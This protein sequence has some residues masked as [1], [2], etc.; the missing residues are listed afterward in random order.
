MAVACSPRAVA[1]TSSTRASRLAS[2]ARSAEMII[3]SSFAVAAPPDDVY[4]LMLDVE[5]VAPC[6]PGAHVTGLRDDGAY[7][8]DVKVKLGPVSMTY[9]GTV[10]VEEHDDAERTARL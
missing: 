6:I 1:S 2:L 3:Q 4:R 7:D 8:A 5:K 10:A 9:R